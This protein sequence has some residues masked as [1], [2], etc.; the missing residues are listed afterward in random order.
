MKALKDEIKR[1]TDSNMNQI[2]V[3]IMFKVIKREVRLLRTR[4]NE[5]EAQNSTQNT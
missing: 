4:T 1:L 3:G 5:L 2:K